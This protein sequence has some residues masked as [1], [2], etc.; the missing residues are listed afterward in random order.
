MLIKY[1]DPDPMLLVS[2]QQQIR[3]T[4]CGAF[5]IAFALHAESVKYIVD[6]LACRISEVYS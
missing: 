1:E 2:V 6:D 5:A 4:D 3:S